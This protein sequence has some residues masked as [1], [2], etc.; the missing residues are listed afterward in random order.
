VIS[1]KTIRFAAILLA[2]TG[3]FLVAKGVYIQ[4]KAIVAQTLLEYSWEQTLKTHKPITPWP[5][6]D[7]WPVARLRVPAHRV[8]TIVLEGDSST[9]LAFGPGRMVLSAL[10]GGP[11]NFVVSGHRDTSFRFVKDLQKGEVIEVQEA[12][13]DIHQYVVKGFSIEESDDIVLDLYDKTP[14]LTLITCY[15]FHGLP[16][17][18]KRYLVFAEEVRQCRSHAYGMSNGCRD[19]TTGGGDHTLAPSL[20]TSR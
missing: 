7:T 10:P 19:A 16:G 9:V 8:D 15:P 12:T 6:S 17:G 13:G 20:R 1:S 11:G 2:V 3:S 5:W 14:R 18:H 4:A